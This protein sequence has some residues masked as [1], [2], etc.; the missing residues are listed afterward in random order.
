LRALAG[1]I[2]CAIGA[3]GIVVPSLAPAF[4]SV[5]LA[6]ALHAAPCSNPRAASTGYEEP[7]LVF[8]AGT[9]TR[10]TDATGAADFLRGGACR[11]AFVEHGEQQAFAVR[12]QAIGLHYEAGPHI[13]GFNISTGRRID[14]GVFKSAGAP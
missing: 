1:A 5:A 6:D 12:A 9:A 3:F 14:V 10:L 11:Y 8:L 7:S 2:L 4:P 13:K